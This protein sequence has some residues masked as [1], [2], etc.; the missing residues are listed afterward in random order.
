MVSADSVSAVIVTRGDVNLDPILDTLPFEAFV[1]DNSQRENLQCYGRFAAL[2][3]IRT[4][5][6]YVQDDDL[7]IDPLAL[8]SHYDGTGILANVPTEEEWDFIGGGAFFP[9]VLPNF[10][11]YLD[12]Y[13]FD[14]DF[15]RVCDVVFAYGHPYR[16]TWVG[17]REILPWHDAENRMYK[18]GD[19]YLVRERARARTLVLKGTDG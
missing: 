13:G 18:Q 8:L 5:H 9:R 12:L 3:Q 19:H 16:R 4:P 7:T 17:Y 10:R 11:P 2:E 6:V 14:S 15:C 1:W